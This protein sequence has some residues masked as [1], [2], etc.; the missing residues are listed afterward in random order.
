MVVCRNANGAKPDKYK[1]GAKDM[2]PKPKGICARYE[3]VDYKRVGN[4]NQVWIVKEKSN[5]PHYWRKFSTVRTIKSNTVAEKKA[6]VKK[7]VVKRRIVPVAVTPAH[8][9]PARVSPVKKT[10]VK[11][12][13]VPVA[14]TPKPV[15]KARR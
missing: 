13:I 11:R 10:V 7:T 2:S 1:L 4:D 15:A 9:S 8:V 3:K 14:V 6:A 12:R 5:G